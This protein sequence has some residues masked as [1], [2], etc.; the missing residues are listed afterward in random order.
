MF[1][2]SYDDGLMALRAQEA[3]IPRMERP[4]VEEGADR[5]RASMEI[6]ARILGTRRMTMSVNDLRLTHVPA[7]KVGVPIR[8]P[9][10][11][12]F[13]AFADP[14]VTTRFWFT[15]S[16]GPMT[17]GATLEWR[18]E[19]Q[20]VSTKVSV[21]EVDQD[22]R[23]VFEWNDQA[24]T[25]VEFRFVPWEESST[26]I[27]VTETGLSGDGD[28]V[29]AHVAGSTAG[30]YQTLCAAKALLEHGVELNV[31]RDQGLFHRSPPAGLE[32]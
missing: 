16:T 6:A 10:C 12:V 19:I 9:P 20:G 27:E 3:T 11:E 14:D 1:A 25:T 2:G 17:A 29:L 28:E 22:S 24:P 31:V 5:G 13:R 7:V 23:I 4:S 8:R 21:R 26:Y 15:H 32:S 30:F 18:W